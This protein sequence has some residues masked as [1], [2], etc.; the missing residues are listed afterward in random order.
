V[1]SRWRCEY[2]E[3]RF[4]VTDWTAREGCGVMLKRKG[5]AG[6]VVGVW[7]EMLW[8][9]AAEVSGVVLVGGVVSEGMV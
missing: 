2:V 7:I 8:R 3:G 9:R 4:R 6:E 5:W 1:G